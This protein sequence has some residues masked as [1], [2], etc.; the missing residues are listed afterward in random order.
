M[1]KRLSN[2]NKINKGWLLVTQFSTTEVSTLSGC[3]PLTLTFDF[4][5]Q[6]P[7]LKGQAK[8]EQELEAVSPI[9]SFPPSTQQR[10]IQQT[11]EQ[12]LEL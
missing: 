10:K 3:S 6:G 2:K 11:N 1:A 8:A 5:R 4:N 7:K 12:P 9:S